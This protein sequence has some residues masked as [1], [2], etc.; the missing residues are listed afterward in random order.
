MPLTPPSIAMPGRPDI[1]VI[2]GAGVPLTWM[3]D[4]LTVDAEALTLEDEPR[5][6]LVRDRWAPGGGGLY[7]ASW[8]AMFARSASRFRSW[9]RLSQAPPIQKNKM[10]T[11]MIMTMTTHFQCV[12][13]LSR[14]V[15]DAREVK[16]K[17]NAGSLAH[18]R[19][20]FFLHTN[21]F[22][23][24]WLSCSLRQPRQSQSPW[25]SQKS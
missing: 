15:S 14:T 1:A 13:S 20:S 6:M 24:A 12:E 8:A 21:R 5:M 17:E 3:A 11:K 22:C 16:T 4:P 9:R 25:Q 23:P 19:R 2:G 10:A 18:R 7:G